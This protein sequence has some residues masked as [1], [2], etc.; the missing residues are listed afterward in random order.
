MDDDF[1]KIEKYHKRRSSE[2]FFN[3]LIEV[4]K[5]KLTNQDL[6]YAAYLYLNM[7]NVQISN[8][9]K[10]ETKTVCMA[11][12]RLKQKIGLEKK[13]IYKHLF[14]VYFHKKICRRLSTDFLFFILS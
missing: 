1:N 5:N 3:K 10:V 2:F 6:K 8:V 7:D 4:S 9:M 12:Y 11:K 14:K 13:L